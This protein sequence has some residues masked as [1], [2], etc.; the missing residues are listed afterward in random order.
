METTIYTIGHSNHSIQGFVS[1]L[2]RHGITALCDVRSV[3]RSRFNPQ[4]DSDELKQMLRDGGILYVFLGKELGARS[5]DPNCYRNGKVRYDLLA[6]TALFRKGIDRVVTGSKNYVLA[7]MCA[8]KEPNNCHRSIL[9]ARRL[10]ELGCDVEHI[11]EDGQTESHF[12]SINRLVNTLDRGNGDLFAGDFNRVE[13]AYAIQSSKIAYTKASGGGEGMG[14]T[15]FSGG[16]QI[17]LF[18]IGFTKTTAE[19]F[20]DRLRRS[21]ARKLVDVRLNNVSQLAGFAKRDDLKYFAKSICG[22]SYRH[23]PEL[24]PTQEILDEYKKRKGVWNVYETKFRKLMADRQIEKMGRNELNGGCLLCSEDKPH[25][26]HRR[27]VAEYLKEKWDNVD[28]VHL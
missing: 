16:K 17:T 13:R 11:L 3:P 4:F 1:L 20:F 12:H 22:M 10:E 14:G 7:V 25:H 28:I 23:I 24:A 6:R 19:N 9:I 27:L 15:K 21:G 5:D 2:R 8:E 18:T 26:C